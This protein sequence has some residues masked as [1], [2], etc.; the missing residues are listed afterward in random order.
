ESGVKRMSILEVTG[1]RVR[2]GGVVAV[3]GIDLSLDLG[4]IEVILG[5]NGAGKTSSLRAISGQLRQEAGKIVWDGADISR[6]PSYKVAR[7]GLVLVPEGRKVFA[8]LSVHE[9]LLLGGYVKHSESGRERLLK[10]VLE[11]FP[12]LGQRSRQPAGLLSGGEQQMLALGRAMMSAPKAILMDEPSMGLAPVVVDAV[13]DAIADISS[14][15]IG[16]LMVEQNAMAALRVARSAVVMER[17]H[18]TLTGS[19]TEMRRHPDVVKAFLGDR[20]GK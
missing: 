16:V 2:Y 8:P 11:L 13:M 4:R 3:R 18:L 9:N 14:T 17:G 12:I 1:L 6:W 10:Q 19:A 5:A 15:G 20:A 7:A